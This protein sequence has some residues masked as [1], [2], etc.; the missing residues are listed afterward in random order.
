MIIIVALAILVLCI[1]FMLLGVFSSKSVAERMMS[2]GCVTNYVIVLLC[3]LSL[4]EGRESFVDVAYI[5]GLFGFA[6]NLGLKKLY[7]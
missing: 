2:L 6:V 1:I 5:Y 3:V 7:D 4:L